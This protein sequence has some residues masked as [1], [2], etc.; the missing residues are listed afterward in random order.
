MWSADHGTLAVDL[1]ETLIRVGISRR[2]EMRFTP[3]NYVREEN[4]ARLRSG[5]DDPSIGLKE[6]IGPLG[7]TFD[8][9]V[10]VGSGIPLHTDKPKVHGLSPFVKLP[11]SHDLPEG[12]SIG[13]MQS[14]FYGTNDQ[15]NKLVGES[16]IYVEREV[17]KHSDVFVEYGADYSRG[18][19]SRQVLHI[20]AARRV[21]P[22]QQIDFHFGFGLTHGS[23]NHF[24][25]AGYSFRVDHLFSRG[26]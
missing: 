11:W 8:L 23:P 3:P 1:S 26:D 19:E 15:P 14:L 10:I 21:T 24:F 20:G 5:F 4:A 25:A 22:R 12:W 13:G 9:S 2:T 18:V 16:T 17:I 7:R 6:Q